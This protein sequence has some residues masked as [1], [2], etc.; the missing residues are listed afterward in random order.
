[1]QKI[2]AVSRSGIIKRFTLSL[3]IVGAVCF[4]AGALIGMGV[5]SASSA[6][7]SDGV[8]LTER[9]VLWG[10]YDGSEPVVTE[11]AFQWKTAEDF[12]PLDVPLDEDVQELIYS[13]SQLYCIDWTLVMAIIEHE[14]GYNPSVISSTN[15]Y[16]L[17]Q[18]NK[19][20]HKWLS[21][22]VGVSDFLDPYQ[23][24]TAGCYILS[25][26]FEKYGDTDQVLM[27]YSLGENGAS[28]LWKQGI[29]ESGFSQEI[30]EI[31]RRLNA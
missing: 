14:S 29:F 7:S 15:D 3:A 26:L 9:T 4:A 22:A 8:Y 12:E 5:G 30:T 19:V 18:I 27:A 16:G 1:M 2:K 6:A 31:Q 24:V 25:Q 17:M 10:A 11:T 13:L 21:E 23:N 20:N 28:K